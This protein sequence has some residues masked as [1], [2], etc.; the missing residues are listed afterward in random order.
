MIKDRVRLFKTTSHRGVTNAQRDRCK[1]PRLLPVGGEK[2]N[3]TVVDDLHKHLHPSVVVCVCVCC[4]MM[5]DTVQRKLDCFVCVVD[6]SSASAA[7]LH[8]GLHI[9]LT[10][11]IMAA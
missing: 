5:G 2:A 1:T 6:K 4:E 9:S 3:Q 10:Q 11:H 8:F 7:D